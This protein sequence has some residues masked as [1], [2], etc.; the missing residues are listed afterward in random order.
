MQ[1]LGDL[2]DD[3]SDIVQRQSPRALQS[4]LEILSLEQLHNH[5]RAA[6]LHAIV[7]YLDDMGAGQASGVAGFTR[8]PFEHRATFGQIGRAAC[9]ERG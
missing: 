7:M 1:C 2:I 3:K 5:E 9:R 8:E 4:G 6:L